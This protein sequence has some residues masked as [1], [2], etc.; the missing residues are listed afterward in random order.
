MAFDQF[1]IF[2]YSTL[3]IRPSV[4]VEE[5]ER[6][7]FQQEL[8]LLLRDISILENNLEMYFALSDVE[9]QFISHVINIVSLLLLRMNLV[10]Y[11]SA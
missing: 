3:G 6:G 2:I 8:L 4:R 9:T 10:T 5:H 1:L 7:V 11:D